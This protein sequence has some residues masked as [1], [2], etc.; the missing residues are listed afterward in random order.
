MLSLIQ[1]PEAQDPAPQRQRSRG[2]LSDRTASRFCHVSYKSSQSVEVTKNAIFNEM[3]DAKVNVCKPGILTHEVE[4][5]NE[6]LVAS[7]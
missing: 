6:A 5:R 4:R 7:H 3:S 2:R 1:E